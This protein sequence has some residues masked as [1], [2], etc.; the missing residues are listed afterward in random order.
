MSRNVDEAAERLASA[1][2]AA[3]RNFAKHDPEMIRDVA[4]AHKRAWKP[5]PCMACDDADPECELC[6]GAAL[7]ELARAA[8]PSPSEEPER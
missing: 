2:D 4:K 6:G 5:R 3:L 8:T 1:S 7:N